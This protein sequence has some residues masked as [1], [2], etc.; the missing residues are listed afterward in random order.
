[1][2]YLYKSDSSAIIYF[3]FADYINNLIKETVSM[4]KFFF[5]LY[6]LYCHHHSVVVIQDLKI[7]SAIKGNKSRFIKNNY[8]HYHLAIII[9]YPTLAIN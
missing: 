6:S 1:M 2:L 5:D 7:V 4:W 8:S 3:I 9:N